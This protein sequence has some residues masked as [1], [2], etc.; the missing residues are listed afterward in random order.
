[1]SLY[2]I[3]DDGES[4]YVES[5]SMTKAINLWMTWKI[6]TEELSSCTEPD[7]CAL[8]DSG[9]VIRDE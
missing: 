5:D 7:S 3:Q 1:M 9:S 6:K 2:L 4:Y 8:V